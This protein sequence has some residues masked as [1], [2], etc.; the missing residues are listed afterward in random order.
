MNIWQIIR[1]LVPF[2]RPY[3]WLVL[4]SLGLTMIGA[5]VTVSGLG[6]MEITAS[7]RKVFLDEAPTLYGLA[8]GFGR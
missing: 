4:A 2:V 3:R 6:S 8:V 7:I 1:R 5:G